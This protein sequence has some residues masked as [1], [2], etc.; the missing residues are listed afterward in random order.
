MTLVLKGVRRGALTSP[1]RR[2]RRFCTRLLAMTRQIPNTSCRV[3]VIG[4]GAA[5]L[6]SLRELVKEGHKVIGFEQNPRPGGVWVYDTATDSDPLAARP[7]RRRV[8]SS[9]YRDLRTNLPREL[10]GFS[11]VPFTPAMLGAASMDARRFCSHSEVL[12]YLDLF[13]EMHQLHQYVQYSTQV[14]QVTPVIHSNGSGSHS[15]SN[16]AGIHFLSGNNSS[17][18]SNSHPSNSTSNDDGAHSSSQQRPKWLIQTMH[19]GPEGL[20]QTQPHTQEFD[21]VVVANGHYNEPNLPVVEGADSWSGLQLHSHNYRIPEQFAGQ[22]V[23][24]VGA[25]NSGV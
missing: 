12:A 5:G 23:V 2:S 1:V 6:V 24:V 7:D 4:A 13:A 20:P 11:D 22:T 16:E 9:M 25:S 10:M 15:S 14:L 17:S 3:A 8:H 19:M 21:A 18:S